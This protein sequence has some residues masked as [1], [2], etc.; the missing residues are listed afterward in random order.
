ML[1]ESSVSVSVMYNEKNVIESHISHI[2]TVSEYFQKFIAEK[3]WNTHTCV[4]TTILT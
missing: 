3:M 2:R 1:G 4:H